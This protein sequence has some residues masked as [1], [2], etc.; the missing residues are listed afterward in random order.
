MAHAPDTL[1]AAGFARGVTLM[2]VSEAAWVTM[3][4][5][6]KYLSDTYPVAQLI[7]FRNVVGLPILLMIVLHAGG[8]AALKT[9]RAST[10]TPTK[11]MTIAAQRRKPTC[12]LRIGTL[13]AV[14]ISGAM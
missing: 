10:S 5:L 4:A 6:I 13:S 11:P 8:W 2:L 1:D 9:T 7:F 3:N 14:I 12:S